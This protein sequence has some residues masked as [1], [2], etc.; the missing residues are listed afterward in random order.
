M[1][2]VLTSHLCSPLGC[3]VG[4]S[5]VPAGKEHRAEGKAFPIR[6]PPTSRC[7]HYGKNLI[8]NGALST[9]GGVV[10]NSG[11]GGR[12]LYGGTASWARAA[13]PLLLME[14][15]LLGHLLVLEELR[16]IS[17]IRMSEG[18]LQ[19]RVKS[20]TNGLIKSF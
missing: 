12:L 8:K 7:I 15:S 11:A 18:F 19:H 20:A 16:P 1:S 9:A 2:R 6:E 4:L 14:G 13:L 10:W 5:A 17:H 3:W